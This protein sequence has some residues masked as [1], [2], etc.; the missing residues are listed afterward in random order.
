MST[1][2]VTDSS[3]P[4]AL[5]F[6]LPLHSQIDRSIALALSRNY[7]IR[8]SGWRGEEQE[9]EGEETRSKRVRRASYFRECQLVFRVT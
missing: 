9:G 5:P 2:N 8:F 4:I 3:T 6:T 1:I 7:D